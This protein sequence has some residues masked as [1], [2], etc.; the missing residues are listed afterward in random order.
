[1]TNA[2]CRHCGTAIHYSPAFAEWHA[3]PNALGEHYMNVCSASFGTGHSPAYVIERDQADGFNVTR[4]GEVF[5]TATDERAAR[6]IANL[7]A[8]AKSLPLPFPATPEA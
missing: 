2:T 8:F 4:N 3:E 6:R 5:A 7:D 1:M